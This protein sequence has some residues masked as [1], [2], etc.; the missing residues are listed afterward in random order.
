MG[1][2][3]TK[4]T[5][6]NLQTLWLLESMV[7]LFVEERGESAYLSVNRLHLSLFSLS[8]QFLTP[9]WAGFQLVMYPKMTLNL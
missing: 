9:S 2:M 5:S 6:H 3:E 4:F 8:S 1:K 7:G